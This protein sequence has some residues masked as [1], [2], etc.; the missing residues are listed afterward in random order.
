MQPSGQ[1]SDRS[2]ADARVDADQPATN[3]VGTNKP[4]T[5]DIGCLCMWPTLGLSWIVYIEA[6]VDMR[7]MH[8]L[9]LPM[10]MCHSLSFSA[11]LLFSVYCIVCSSTFW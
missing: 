10:L 11:W 9:T 7:E 3:K 1:A 6:V 5:P 8:L 4:R 2:H